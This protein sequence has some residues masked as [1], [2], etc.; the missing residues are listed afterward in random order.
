V[1]KHARNPASMIHEGSRSGPGGYDVWM[2]ALESGRADRRGMAVNTST[3]AAR[4]ALAVEFL[5]E[6]AGRLPDALAPVLEDYRAVARALHALKGLFPA[7]SG[8][9]L[10]AWRGAALPGRGSARSGAGG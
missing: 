5:E 4:R 10:A 3:W 9:G 6:A 7:V 8:G 2:A 1:L